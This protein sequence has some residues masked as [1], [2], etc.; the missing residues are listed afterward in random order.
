[1]EPRQVQLLLAIF[2]VASFVIKDTS[3]ELLRDIYARDLHLKICD[4]A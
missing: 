2:T 1:M 3:L 4:L